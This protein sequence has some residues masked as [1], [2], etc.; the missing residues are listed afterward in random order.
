MNRLTKPSAQM[1]RGMGDGRDEVGRDV[2]GWIGSIVP[3]G[4]MHPDSR[5]EG[6]GATL[7]F[8]CIAAVYH[9]YFVNIA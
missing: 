1:V 8:G 6:S 5:T 9:T 4:E 3:C 7:N 2:I